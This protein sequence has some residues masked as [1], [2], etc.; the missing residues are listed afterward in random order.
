MIPFYIYSLLHIHSA[1][2]L[3]FLMILIQLSHNLPPLQTH[4]LHYQPHLMN[5]SHFI[6][7][8][9]SKKVPFSFNFFLIHA[10]NYWF[11]PF[12]YF[13]FLIFLIFWFF[14]ESNFF[15]FPLPL[16]ILVFL[17]LLP[18]FYFFLVKV[19]FKIVFFFLQVLHFFLFPLILFFRFLRLASFSSLQLFSLDVW[20]SQN[21]H[22]I[23]N[24]LLCYANL[25]HKLKK[26]WDFQK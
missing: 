21:S 2:L 6:H 23:K 13:F 7:L 18:W 4:F 11:A 25:N 26:V 9:L 16:I 5:F 1:F 8:N 17:I 20:T 10:F 15:L 12:F 24:L 3:H 19:A 14:I 22:F